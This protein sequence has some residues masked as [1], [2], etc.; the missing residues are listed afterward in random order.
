M[1]KKWTKKEIDF[2]KKKYPINGKFWCVKKLNRS[3]AS[4][5]SM[6]AILKLRISQDSDFS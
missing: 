4:I 3:E 2:L 1:Q 5:R 6:A